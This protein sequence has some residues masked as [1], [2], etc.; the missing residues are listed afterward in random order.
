MGLICFSPVTAL[1]R[2]GIMLIEPFFSGGE[3]I[4]LIKV[5]SSLCLVDGFEIPDL[6]EFKKR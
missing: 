1:F 2:G 5:K 4:K 3:L 6:A